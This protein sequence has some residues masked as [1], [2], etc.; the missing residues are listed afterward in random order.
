MAILE[1][2]VRQLADELRSAV[3]ASV[4]TPE[5]LHTNLAMALSQGAWQSAATQ[6]RNGLIR[7]IELVSTHTMGTDDWPES[8]TFLDGKTV[9]DGTF[10]TVWRVLGLKGNTFGSP[11]QSATLRDLAGRRN[12]VAH[13]EETVVQAGRTLTF[14]DLDKKLQHVDDVLAGLWLAVDDWLKT[15]GWRP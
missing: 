5:V 8:F 2:L 11:I 4:T 12:R 10:T 3:Q 9:N 15:G 7:R 6:D 14:G 13:G 1:E